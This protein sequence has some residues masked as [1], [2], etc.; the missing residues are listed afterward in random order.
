MDDKL[1]SASLKF[2]DDRIPLLYFS[3]E[4]YIDK[5]NKI[6]GKSYKNRIYKFPE[7]LIR[8]N[9]IGCSMVFNRTF[10]VLIAQHIPLK[11]S[12][13]DSYIF[14]LASILKIRMVLD[15]E[16][17]FL[18]RLHGRNFSGTSLN[19]FNFL[20]RFFRE[21]SFIPVLDDLKE[22]LN[23]YNS[24]IEYSTLKRINIL[25][26]HRNSFILRMRFL[27]SEYLLTGTIFQKFTFFLN[28]LFSKYY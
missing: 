24:L 22:I 5:D 19:K 25:L 1:Y 6:I 27:F 14:R 2:S 13:H 21:S 23:G 11:I 12:M 18:Y 10:Y 4:L 15:K 16:P 20:K 26:N 8:S 7:S 17:H 28:T 9:V 3:N